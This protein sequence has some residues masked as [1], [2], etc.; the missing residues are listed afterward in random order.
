M[1]T[2][3]C[4]MKIKGSLKRLWIDRDSS[5]MNVKNHVNKIK[6][7]ISLRYIE[8]KTD[9]RCSALLVNITL[10]WIF[11]YLCFNKKFVFYCCINSKYY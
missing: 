9:R 11:L 6:A 10:M 4:S 1:M 7:K 3:V 8:Y 2:S 5:V